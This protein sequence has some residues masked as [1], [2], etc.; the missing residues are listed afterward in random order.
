[1]KPITSRSSIATMALL[2]RVPGSVLTWPADG[3]DAAQPLMLPAGAGGPTLGSGVK[4]MPATVC[5][6]VGV[7]L[8]VDVGVALAV[9]VAVGVGVGEMVVAGRAVGPA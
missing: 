3:I 6:A 7:G 2:A 9:A 1:M 5:S 4:A 8:A